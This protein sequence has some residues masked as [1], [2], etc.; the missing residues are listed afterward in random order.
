[1]PLPSTAQITVPVGGQWKASYTFTDDDGRRIDISTYAW[2]FSIRPS[3]ADLSSPALVTV[4]SASATGQGYIT[5]TTD[6]STALVVLAPAATAL[7]TGTAY[8]YALW[9][10]P[11]LT[12]AEPWVTG[13]CYPEPVA[14]P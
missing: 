13:P 4:S 3:T 11:G 2:R 10:D 12:D 5:V 8:V 1:M 14:A 6:T 7:L 9:M